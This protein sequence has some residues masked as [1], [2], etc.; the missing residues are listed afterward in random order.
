MRENAALKLYSLSYN[1]YN[2]SLWHSSVWMLC[3]RR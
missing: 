2:G 1:V 3:T